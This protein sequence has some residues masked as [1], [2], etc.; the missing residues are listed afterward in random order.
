MKSP[1]V[2]REDS[3]H[4]FFRFGRIESSALKTLK[5]LKALGALI[6]LKALKALKAL[7]ALRAL[8]ALRALNALKALK[9]LRA[10]GLVKI[11]NSFKIV[12]TPP[13]DLEPQ[14]ISEAFAAAFGTLGSTFGPSKTIP[15]PLG[16]QLG[17]FWT[18]DLTRLDSMQPS[19]ALGAFWFDA[20]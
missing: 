8:R 19:Q 1:Q 12:G 2:C 7:Q 5:G 13:F 17:V 3:R 6:A 20:A 15:E 14:T 16:D 10:N 9:A 18:L 11:N 4:P